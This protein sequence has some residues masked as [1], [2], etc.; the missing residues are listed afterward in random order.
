[1]VSKEEEEQDQR[2]EET[3]KEEITAIFND[4]DLGRAFH[5]GIALDRIALDGLHHGRKLRYSDGDMRVYSYPITVGYV[6][7]PL[8]VL[9]SGGWVSRRSP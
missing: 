5:F 9:S 8:D 2:V 7:R 6:Q 3:V 1:M 4:F